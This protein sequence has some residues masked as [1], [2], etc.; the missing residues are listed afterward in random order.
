MPGA[1]CWLSE[2]FAIISILQMKRQP[3]Q[4]D[5]SG[6]S[7]LTAAPVPSTLTSC[8]QGRLLWEEASFGPFHSVV[9][10]TSRCVVWLAS[11]AP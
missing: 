3:V 11:G 9:S 2:E 1:Q 4:A 5:G 8:G 10:E 7:P 6:S